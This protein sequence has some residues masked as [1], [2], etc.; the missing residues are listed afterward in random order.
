MMPRKD[1]K[2]TIDWLNV[3]TLDILFVLFIVVTSLVAMRNF[4]LRMA[5]LHTD[6]GPILYAHVAKTPDLFA[7]D[8]QVGSPILLRTRFKVITSAMVWI[9]TLLWKYLNIDPYLST[10][11]ITFWQIISIGIS[12]YF[13][14]LE[15]TNKR[16]V[17]ILAA[18]FA[19]SAG[20]WAWAPANYGNSLNDLLFPYAANLAIAP[21][22]F[23]FIYLP[24]ERISLT[25]FFLL[26]GGL[27]HPN[28]AVYAGFIIGIYW[29]WV[30]YRKKDKNF[31]KPILGLAITG[32]IIILP[33]L[34]V[35]LAYAGETPSHEVLMA[36]I[37]QNQHIWPWGFEGRWKYSSQITILWLILALL[38]F[39]WVGELEH[40]FKH[41]WVATL[42]GA[43]LLGFSQIIGTI[44]EIPTLL[45]L[46]GLRSFLWLALISLPLVINYWYKYL[47]SGDWLGVLLS[48]LFLSLPLFVKEYALFSVLVFAFIF[49]D[50]SQ[51]HILI[52]KIALSPKIRYGFKVTAGG[53]LLAF[54]FIF[55]TSSKFLGSFLAEAFSTLSTRSIFLALCLFL[56]FFI[57]LLHK[58]NFIDLKPVY[59]LNSLLI[60]GYASGLLWKI[61]KNE[62]N[63]P[64]ATVSYLDVQLWAKENTP[65]SSLFVVPEGGWRTMSL[66]RRLSPFTRENYAYITSIEAMEHRERLLAFYGILSSEALDMKGDDIYYLEH[67]LFENFDEDDFLRFNT[68]FG[69][70]YLVL[71]I[72]QY[73]EK[74]ELCFPVAYQNQYY[75][76]YKLQTLDG[77]CDNN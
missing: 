1:K 64:D 8:Y 20:V 43:S 49:L 57:H 46:I 68:E 35:Q 41:L 5:N 28:L 17:A 14:S 3:K 23:S 62:K 55:I 40:K 39:R 31:W 58:E 75:R 10:W 29:L 66:R 13:F 45:N 37:R 53:F 54:L 16:V 2:T 9:P 30:G 38:S 27:I 21:I 36:G 50:I 70:R 32:I 34:S 72:Y 69:A 76:V 24:R 47:R 56:T 15:I 74:P 77:E 26:I 11:A 52:W 65:P 67:E 44:F 61:W 19:Y 6:D 59:I 42:I 18:L 7:G 4:D 22:L 51:E 71:S 63:I 60:L 12:I 48:I 73:P 25:F 33:A